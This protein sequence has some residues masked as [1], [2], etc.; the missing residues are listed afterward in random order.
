MESAR[1]CPTF[2]TRPMLHS[3]HMSQLPF[4]LTAPPPPYARRPQM[5]TRVVQN[6]Q[7][8]FWLVEFKLNW[9]HPIYLSIVPSVI[10]YCSVC[11][12]NCLLLSIY[13]SVCNSESDCLIILSL[14]HAEYISFNLSLIISIVLSHKNL[15]TVILFFHF[16]S[17]F[18]FFFSNPTFRVCTDKFRVLVKNDSIIIFLTFISLHSNCNCASCTV[19]FLNLRK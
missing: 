12:S 19:Y 10:L 15:E 4:L 7:I 14:C 1:C 11:R 6:V 18:K 16:F 3:C 2:L 13:R 9:P 17:T 8:L 5:H